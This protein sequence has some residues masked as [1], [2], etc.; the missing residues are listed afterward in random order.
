MGAEVWGLAFSFIHVPLFFSEY[1]G[2]C[3]VLLGTFEKVSNFPEP[4][5]ILLNCLLRGDTRGLFAGPAWGVGGGG[6]GRKGHHTGG[7]PG[8]PSSPATCSSLG[9]SFLFLKRRGQT[10]CLWGPAT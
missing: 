7:H 3:H 4:H 2:H 1:F 6:A 9:L 10:R 8:P 5:F